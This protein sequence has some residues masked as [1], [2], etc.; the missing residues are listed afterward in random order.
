MACWIEVTRRVALSGAP[1]LHNE[2]DHELLPEQA[3]QPTMHA[4]VRYL[5]RL[6]RVMRSRRVQAFAKE[7]VQ[8][9]QEPLSS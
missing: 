5:V 4:E 9:Q 8:G 7:I 2:L 6:R 3:V 1:R